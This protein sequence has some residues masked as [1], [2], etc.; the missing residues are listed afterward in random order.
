M[1]NRNISGKTLEGAI[2]SD[3]I[4]G[5]E[6]IDVDGRI[7]GIAEKIFIDSHKFNLIGIDID[8]GVLKKGL[9]IGKNYIRK[10]TP[11]AIFL[12]ISVAYELKGMLVFD[13]DGAEVGKVIKVGLR[14]ARN[15]IKDI[16][17]RRGMFGSLIIPRKHIDRIG[18]NIFL[19]VNVAD[20]E[21]KKEVKEEK[22]G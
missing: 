19:K 11:H 10:I 5:K 13:I 21:P 3:D 22:K 1:A 12:N 4:L 6:V 14:G 8:K 9:T 18:G 16:T 17:V 20:L 2:T 7:I 15:I